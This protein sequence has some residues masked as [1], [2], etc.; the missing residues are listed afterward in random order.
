MISGLNVSNNFDDL[1]IENEAE[2]TINAHSLANMLQKSERS[3]HD[4]QLPTRACFLKWNHS[5]TKH[6]S[7]LFELYKRLFFTIIPF[8]FTILGCAFG[9]KIGRSSDKTSVQYVL[10]LSLF[11]FIAYLLGK[12]LHK[13][14]FIVLFLYLAPNCAVLSLCLIFFKRRERGIE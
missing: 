8:T 13:H 9:L 5:P 6:R 1:I 2:M 10:M 4:D 12:S 14:P 11:I 3:I 7:T